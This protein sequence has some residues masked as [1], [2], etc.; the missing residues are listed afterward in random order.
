MNKS[1]GEKG[2]EANLANGSIADDTINSITLNSTVPEE[3]STVGTTEAAL[4][5]VDDKRNDDAP[6]ALLDG[7]ESKHL[8][9]DPTTLDQEVKAERDGEANGP[10]VS[11]QPG[12]EQ[13]TNDDDD[14]DESSGRLSNVL[15]EPVAD[16][17]EAS[18]RPKRYELTYW[19]YHLS[20]AEKLWKVE[21][22]EKSDEWKELW[23]L[24]IKFLCESPDVFKIWQHHY[25]DLG[26]KYISDTTLLSP[27]QVAAGYGMPGLVKL[28]LGRGESATTELEDGRSAL[29]FGADSPDIEVIKLLL[30]NGANPN[31]IKEFESPFQIMLRWNPKIEFVNMMLKYGADCNVADPW[32]F[33]AMH[34]FALH[35]SDVEVFK[36]L[37]EAHGDISIADSYGETPLHI[38]MYNAQGLILELLRAFLENGADVNKDDKES[39]SKS[40]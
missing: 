1:T 32:G 34:W 12:P 37:L 26:E 16:S 33:T 24:V 25:M 35:G 2:E 15:D 18:M 38:L 14:D 8:R 23:R 9:E 11:E 6:K 13:I 21:E 5:S 28:L 39:Q 22:R 7:D 20:S 36:L 29:W 19:P 31:A 27:L 30:E 40:S 17:A 10:E 3:K 4:N